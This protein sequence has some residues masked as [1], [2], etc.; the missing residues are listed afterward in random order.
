MN[1]NENIK[2]A[3]NVTFK[4]PLQYKADKLKIFQDLNSQIRGFYFTK[5]LINEVEKQKH[6]EKHCVY[7]LFG[8]ED[9]IY[10]GQSEN[11]IYRIKSHV[12][13]KI[14]W[15]Y[16]IMFVSDNGTFDKTT[17]DYLENYFI[18]SFSGSKYIL[19]NKQAKEKETHTNDFETVRY[20]NSAKQIEFLLMCNGINIE[21]GIKNNNIKN[22]RYFID[23]KNKAKLYVE[24]GKYI[25]GQG[26]II[27][28]EE[29]F[30]QKISE[31]KGRD[32]V[33]QYERFKK[34][35]L[36]LKK[37]NSLIKKDN[38]YLTNKDFWFDSPSRP[39]SLVSGNPSNGWE[40]WQGLNK[41]REKEN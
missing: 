28:T 39:A 13:N 25:L 35:V 17:I 24:D 20:Y 11:G 18:K 36:Q 16:C 15:T 26:S 38:Y 2:N 40:F 6:S 30:K 22:K 12:E 23:N 8:Q 37:A 1:N 3:R 14:F 9:E 29:Y 34:T 41:I 10:I 5:S 21:S 33:K 19:E 4:Y 32:V 7:F 31:A 27:K